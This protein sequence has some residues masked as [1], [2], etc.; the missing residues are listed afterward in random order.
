MRRARPARKSNGANSRS[1]V[2][3]ISNTISQ[4]ADLT[5]ALSLLNGVG[6]GTSGTQRLGQKISLTQLEYSLALASTPTTGLDQVQRLIIFLDRQTNGAAPTITDVLVS[7]S[8]YAMFNVGNA[9]RFRILVDETK[10]I[11]ASTE[12]DS[13]VVTGHVRKPLRTTQVFN[14]G[15]SADVTDI[16]SGSIYLLTIGSLTAG[17]TAGSVTGRTRLS[18]TDN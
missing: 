12:S 2:K 18:F 13:I 16:V 15:V 4:A 11:N 8:P 9:T 5:G 1:E 10:S 17:A 3:T 6:P 14:T 7:A